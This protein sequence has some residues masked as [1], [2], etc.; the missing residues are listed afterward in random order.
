MATV[1]GQPTEDQIDAALAIIERNDPDTWDRLV[2][3]LNE[4]HEA[5][6]SAVYLAKAKEALTYA[7]TI[8][9]KIAQQASEKPVA[10]PVAKPK[11]TGKARPGPAP[12]Y[13]TS[14]DQLAK[15]EPGLYRFIAFG[16]WLFSMAG[17]VIAFA[18]GWNA[19]EWFTNWF[20][21]AFSLSLAWQV[22]CSAVQF[23]TCRYWYNPVYLLALAASFIPSY[24]GYRLLI[25]VPLTR[26]AT[27]VQGDVFASA[28]TLKASAPNDMMAAAVIHLVFAIG[29]I[30]IDVLP[31][32]ILV[33]K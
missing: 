3:E 17:N 27:G 24:L 19:M 7:I 32:K 2:T 25:A 14:A 20:W 33:K 15:A 22:G 4:A 30:A 9:R 13:I 10:K 11:Q 12:A 16:L 23:I 18:G 21:I 6:D 29:L 8:Q 28:A 5:E 31:E 1:A 26:W